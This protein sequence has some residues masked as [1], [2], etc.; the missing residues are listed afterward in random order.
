ME[1]T[2]KSAIGYL[3]AFE[4]SMKAAS[5]RDDGFTSKQEEKDLKKLNKLTDKYI[6][7]LESMLD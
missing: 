4:Q 3:K 6:E 5:L 1:M 7:E 2:I